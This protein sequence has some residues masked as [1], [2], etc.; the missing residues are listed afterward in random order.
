M[1]SKDIFACLK[2]HKSTQKSFFGIYPFDKLPNINKLR[3][4]NKDQKQIYIIVNTQPSSKPGEH[5]F[6]LCIQNNKNN[7][8]HEYFDSYGNKPPPKIVQYLENFLIFSKKQIQNNL[9]TTCGQWCMYY[10]LFKN[11]G[12]SLGQLIAYIL[13]QMKPSHRDKF[14]NTYVTS[15]FPKKDMLVRDVSFII[16][17]IALPKNH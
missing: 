7:L 13:E 8:P 14:V 6:A 16:N 11:H 3:K 1:N 9:T 12:G 15:Q 10:I 5:W 2:S 4:L 17:Q